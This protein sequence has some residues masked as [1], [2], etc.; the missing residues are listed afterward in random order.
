MKFCPKFCLPCTWACTWTQCDLSF[1]LC[2]SPA[3][4]IRRLSL[5]PLTPLPPSTAPLTLADLIKGQARDVKSF[6]LLCHLHLELEERHKI[7]QLPTD[8]ISSIREATA[9]SNSSLIS[10]LQDL[11][12]LALLTADKGLLAPF[13]LPSRVNYAVSDRECLFLPVNASMAHWGAHKYSWRALC[14]IL[15]EFSE[16]TK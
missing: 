5:L 2:L 15:E 14:S 7:S 11:R 12:W 4:V 6:F 9:L 10:W 1:S 13:W 8:L 16:E 3:C